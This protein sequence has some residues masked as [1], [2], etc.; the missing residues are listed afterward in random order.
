MKKLVVFCL[1]LT[2]CLTAKA[3]HITGGEMYYTS[4]PVQSGLVRYSVTLK[5]FMRCNSGRQFNNPAIVSIFNKT[6]NVRV[7]NVNVSLTGQQSISLSDAGPCV[8][9]PPLV[10]YVIGTYQFDVDLPS[11]PDGYTLASQVNYRIA[12]ITNLS[13]GYSNIGATYTCEIPGTT[14]LT[15]GPINNSAKFIGSDLVVVCANNRFAYSF[16]AQDADGDQL[17]YSFC[18]AYV[19][20]NAG[21]GNTSVPTPSPPYASVPYGPP[22]SASAPLGGEVQ[23]NQN[24]GLITG[25]APPTGIYVVTV[26][27]EE[28]RNG[29][30]I[31]RQRKDLQINIAACDI[32]AAILDK[33]YQLCRDTKTL[34]LTNLST[35]ILIKSQNWQIKDRA[36]IVIFDTV[37]TIATYTF[38]DTGLYTIKLVINRGQGCSDSTTSLARVYPGFAPSFNYA[39]ICFNRPTNFINTSTTVY[40]TVNS[41]S[42][43]YG[44]LG[45]ADTSNRANDSYTYLSMG[46]KTALLT[47][48]NSNGCVDTVTRFIPIFDKPPL[49]LAF[50]DTLICVNDKLQLKANG[51]GIYNWTPTVNVI[52]GNTPSPTVSP[53]ATT[54]YY[55]DLDD[56]G[57]LNKDSVMVRV[58]DH[59][60]LRAM[61]DTI[62]CQGDPILLTLSSDGFQYSWTPAA[63]MADANV[64]FP[65]ATTFQVTT[66]EVTARIGGCVAIDQVK[67]T[68]VP[69]PSVNAGAD[70][71]VCFNTSA[72][73]A[74]FTNGTSGRWTPSVF[75]SNS[76]ILNPVARPPQTITYMLSAYDTKGC[77]K[78]GTDTVQVIVLPEIKAFAGNDTSIIIGQELQLT[79]VGGSSYTWVPSIGLSSPFI[80]SPVALYNEPSDGLRYNVFVYNQAGCVDT[81][82]IM[83]KV[84]A[85]E[86]TVFVPTA[87]TPN[88]DGK[89]D[90]LR[91]IAAGIKK[92]EYF[93]IYNR[94]GRLVFTTSEDRKGWDGTFN[95]SPQGTGTF[96]WMVKAV[97]YKSTPYFKKGTVTLIR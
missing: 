1:L 96:V 82:S 35:S 13:R 53:V 58:T 67:V 55:V 29:V 94:W 32:A 91:A 97:D 47:V 69:Y 9:N 95:G 64:R 22:F 39:G 24:T 10:C 20:G 57:C 85:T 62:I 7:S 46:L 49:D 19:S 63:Q 65:T 54:R 43:D 52:N 42:W 12:G 27:V 79:A 80:S 90:V 18:N 75:L 51:S 30:V 31:A 6:T 81:T 72:Q 71:M 21:I 44:D 89:N 40:G 38:A 78:P 2:C 87:F 77:P 8:T 73:L 23:I 50:R 88:N 93:S 86:P 59:V 61:N 26:C 92:L 17:R 56:Q 3:D 41:W 68:P 66:Y 70:T 34:S 74:G 11:S 16:E 14:P 83:I 5:L 84:F 37:G 4:V 60:N 36:G 48:G 33:E 25:T 76:N 45:A 15:N 28:I